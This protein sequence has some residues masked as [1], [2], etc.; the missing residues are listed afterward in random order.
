MRI[1][2]EFAP[3]TIQIQSSEDKELIL[4]M[5]DLALQQYNATRESWFLG[6]E[7]LYNDSFYQRVQYIRKELC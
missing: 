1:N 3:I 4:R 7:K 6:G 5:I 2:K